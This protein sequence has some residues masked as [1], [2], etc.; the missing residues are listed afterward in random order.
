MRKSQ[1]KVS[2]IFLTVI[3]SL[4]LLSGCGLKS[5]AEV[6]VNSNN[7]GQTKPQ[8][9]TFGA[10][11]DLKA[12]AEGE[13]LVFDTFTVFAEKM[14]MAPSLAESWEIKND[15]KTYVLHL[16]KGVKFHNAQDFTADVAKFSLEYWGKYESVDYLKNLDNIKV[17]DA[18]T[19]EVNFKGPYTALISELKNIKATLK[20]SVDDK[21]NIVEYIG[22]GP[23]KLT[24]YLKDQKAVLARNTDYWNK[25]RLP[26]IE[27]VVWQ[28]IPDENA[29]LMA[30]K[31][32]QVDAIG[33]SEHYISLP[34]E[35]IP[36]L[37]KTEGLSVLKQTKE[38][39][40]ATYCFNYKEGVMSDLNLRKAVAYA[41]D[42][43]TMV[44]KV[45]NGVPEASGHFLHPEF[46]D[47]PS[48]EKPYFYDSQL[49]KE[50]LAAAGFK[51]TNGDGIVEKDGKP[52][53]LRLLTKS[54]KTDTDVAVFVQNNLKQVGIDVEIKALDSNQFSQ[55][56]L[57]GNFDI[58]RTHPWI[59][60]A[61]YY[62]VWRGNSDQYDK[63]G[64]GLKADAQFDALKNTALTSF[65]EK[66][67]SAAW[68]KIWELEYS[69]YPATP[70][71][72]QPRVF[73]YKSNI[74]GFK[75][76]PDVVV[77]DLSQVT[78]E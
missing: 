35:A 54:T 27:Q 37:E 14:K 1:L 44:K 15:G 19:L 73:V 56:T 67:R 10:A 16:R 3:M 70:L 65:D 61:I 63:Y 42:R 74:K 23:F 43:E 40:I 34:Y 49:A 25:S 7:N 68:E 18:N 17:V 75:F 39:S 45:L 8:I 20:E 76:D 4:T 22:T 2:A 69:V 77:I 32:G 38:G 66:I 29:R 21:G 52:V 51:D 24:E 5:N 64:I 72:V 53:K 41:I 62:L 28:A 50:A 13:T 31:S 58:A 55:E 11:A 71:Y 46:T 33:V 6:K 47:G 60:P 59:A 48:K 57:K 26:K 9:L 30:I 78:V 36:G 12:S